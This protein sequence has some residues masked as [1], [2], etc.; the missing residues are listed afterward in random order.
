MFMFRNLPEGEYEVTVEAPGYEPATQKV[1]PV[2]GQMNM[3]PFQM[4]PLPAEP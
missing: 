4:K 2:R 3:A 1:T